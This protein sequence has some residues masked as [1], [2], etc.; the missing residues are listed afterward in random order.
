MNVIKSGRLDWVRKQ[1]EGYT[2]VRYLETP[3]KMFPIYFID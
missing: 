2:N 3:P 1:I